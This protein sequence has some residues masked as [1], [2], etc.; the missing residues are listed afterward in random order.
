[1]TQ[2]Y[3]AQ[4][5]PWPNLAAIIFYSLLRIRSQLTDR[6]ILRLFFPYVS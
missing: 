6:Q 2:H 5:L 3:D 4:A 1:M